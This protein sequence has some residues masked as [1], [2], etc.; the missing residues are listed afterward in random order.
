MPP[1]P[2]PLVLA[3]GSPRRVELLRRAGF[4]PVVRPPAVDE[5]PRPGES[6]VDLVARLA[7]AKATAVSASDEAIVVGADTTVVLDGSILGKPA[8][9]EE[10]R[11]ML[12]RLQGRTHLVL[13]GWAVVRRGRVVADG[14]AESRVTMRPVSEDEIVRYVAAGEP[15]DKAGGYALQGEGGRFVTEVEGSTSNVIGLPLEEV[16]PVLESLG[17]RGAGRGD[18]R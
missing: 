8:D 14:V 18:G 3:S 13:T 5:T 6:P 7:A 9:E 11:R 15:M 4:S 2:P 10:A 1:S 17:L 12:R 16:V